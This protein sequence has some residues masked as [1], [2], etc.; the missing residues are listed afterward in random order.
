V[1]SPTTIAYFHETTRPI[2][3]I[4]FTSTLHDTLLNSPVVKAAIQ[5]EGGNYMHVFD[6]ALTRAEIIAGLQLGSEDVAVETHFHRY[7][8]VASAVRVFKTTS[9]ETE[10]G[11]LDI[12]YGRAGQSLD[13][14]QQLITDLARPMSDR[15]RLYLASAEG[16]CCRG[17][18]GFL[19]QNNYRPYDQ[20][21]FEFR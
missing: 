17:K 7:R 14:G 12:V 8:V 5:G 21:S 16:G 2:T 13:E 6:R 1:N 4:K 20:Q 18:P 10:A 15:V 19:V 9:T 11:T 3:W